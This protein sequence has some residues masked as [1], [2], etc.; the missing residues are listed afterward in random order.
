MAIW[1]R[2]E[3]TVFVS[4]VL[5]VLL[6]FL[7][8]ALQSARQAML[9]G[10]FQE[11]LELAE[12][13]MLSEYH[14]ELLGRYGL[15]YLDM[16]YG[17]GAED[18]AYL[19][20]RLRGFLDE[21]LSDGETRGLDTW[22]FS[23]ATDGRGTGYYEQAVACMKERAGVSFLQKMKEYESYG[24]ISARREADYT[25]AD[26]RENRNLEELKRRR[27]E[28]EEESTPDPAE[29]TDRLRQGSIL[30]LVLR[31]PER[32]S[33]KKAD[34]SRAPSNRTLLAGAGPRGRNGP[35]AANDLFFLGYLLE[36]FPHAA[37]FL[38]G[39]E[40]SGAWLDYQ[41]EYLIGGRESDIENLEAVCGRLLAI[42]EG[43]NYVYLLSDAGKVAECTALA[44]ALVG[45]TLIPGL[46]EAMK[47]V[48]LLVW[49]FAE[50]ILDVRMLLNGKRSA[51]YKDSL[52][53]KLSLTGALEL[54]SLTE[55]DEREDEGGLL[56][57]DYLGILL[58]M[59]RRETRV[60]RS[61]DAI[62]GVVREEDGG[63]WFYV[64]Q[65]VDAFWMRAVCVNG[66]ELSAQRWFAYEW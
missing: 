20:Q 24:E 19:N 58:T 59:T 62:E 32:V 5:S 15:F 2:G 22:D 33:G 45:A 56:Y 16:S 8:A 21:N 39:E 52:T 28:E 49:A 12:Y 11:A 53:W 50:S 37:K 42:R 27:E 65:C 29:N 63:R 14:R 7:Q 66:Q 1:R 3:I 44:A 54:G 13:S 26:A 25:E 57:R 48:L 43:M 34:L 60:M 4:L 64:D 6:F 55:F 36:R 23:R 61:L 40:E 35:G 46:V 10:E 51:F 47:Q 9:R 17:G 41:L 38:T 18:T 30:H 31:E